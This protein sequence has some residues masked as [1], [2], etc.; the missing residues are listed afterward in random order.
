MRVAI[1]SS[2]TLYRE[3]IRLW[4]DPIENLVVTG[5]FSTEEEFRLIKANRKADILI[6]DYNEELYSDI[7]LI[8]KLSRRNRRIK[9][10]IVSMHNDQSFHNALKKCG[11]KGCIEKYNLNADI[12][13]ALINIYNGKAHFIAA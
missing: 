13:D 1:I 7:N 5:E 2:S 9:L 10:L 12:K 8:K 11:I 3:V 4:I 6:V